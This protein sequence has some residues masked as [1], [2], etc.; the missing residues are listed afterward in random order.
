MSDIEFTEEQAEK[1]AE[2]CGSVHANA[3]N[4]FVK[5]LQSICNALLTTV[6]SSKSQI[7]K[8]VKQSF[9]KVSA[10]ESAQQETKK[11]KK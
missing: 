7:M 6:E 11:G 3:V 5:D 2:L 9:V 4:N 8:N 10:N 1:I